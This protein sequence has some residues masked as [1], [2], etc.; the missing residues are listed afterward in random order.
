MFTCWNKLLQQ[1]V[2]QTSEIVGEKNTNIRREHVTNNTK[3]RMIESK[4]MKIRS[5]KCPCDCYQYS[6][7]LCYEERSAGAVFGSDEDLQWNNCCDI[8]CHN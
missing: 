8:L 5:I 6:A 4:K 2:K 1:S 7:S 3:K